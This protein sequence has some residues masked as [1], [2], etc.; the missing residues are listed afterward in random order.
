MVTNG[1]FN[2]ADN[3][4]DATIIVFCC[5]SEASCVVCDGDFRP[6]MLVP[7]ES[8]DGVTCEDIVFETSVDCFNRQYAEAL[9]CPSAASTCSIC[10][11]TQ[12][13]AD[14][15]VTDSDGATWTCREVAY[16]AANRE[17]T[18]A[19]C[20]SYH[21]Y[22]EYCC[23]DVFVPS[24][25]STSSPPVGFPTP[26]PTYLLLRYV[27]TLKQADTLR[28]N[29]CSAFAISHVISHLQRG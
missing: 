27:F 29:I 12:L 2:S 14:V 1:L 26:P 11:G 28:L 16:Y 3:I 4:L 25:P 19:D 20:S 17:A 8:I 13:S 23:P 24:V 7:F 15:E 21:S 5:S 9:C 22:E 18:S 10:K 6:D